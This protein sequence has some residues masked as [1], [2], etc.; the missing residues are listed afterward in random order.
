MQFCYRRLLPLSSSRLRFRSK[1][2]A[3]GAAD[4]LKK[5]CQSRASVYKQASCDSVAAAAQY[6]NTQM[7]AQCMQQ[8]KDKQAGSVCFSW[9]G[10][11][12]GD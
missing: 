9:C 10:Y 2:W 3:S 1:A 6:V 4:A 12:Y 11:Y 7:Y 5:D 8:C